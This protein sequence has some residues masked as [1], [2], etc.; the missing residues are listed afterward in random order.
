MMMQVKLPKQ[1]SHTVAW[2]RSEQAPI[3]SHMVRHLGVK[4][5][6]EYYSWVQKQAHWVSKCVYVCVCVARVC[7]VGVCVR[8]WVSF[9]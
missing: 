1:L 3:W 2:F 6:T 5:T 7:L 4:S 8:S 9:T